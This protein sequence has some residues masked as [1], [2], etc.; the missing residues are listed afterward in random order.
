MGDAA[1]PYALLKQV[2][3]TCADA[4][5]QDVSLAV[6]YQQRSGLATGPAA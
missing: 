5:F 3:A 2:L 1:V 4:G 6:E